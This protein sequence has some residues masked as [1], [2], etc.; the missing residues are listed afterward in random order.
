M[1]GDVNRTCHKV[2]LITDK[3]L[4]DSQLLVNESDGAFCALLHSLYGT[5]TVADGNVIGVKLDN[6]VCACSS[7]C[8]WVFSCFMLYAHYF[9]IFL[10]V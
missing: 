5:D 10:S 8:R 3:A 7:I 1:A 6:V 2:T 9:F 4:S